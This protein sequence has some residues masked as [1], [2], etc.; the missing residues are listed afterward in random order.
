MRSYNSV[1][2]IPS[3]SWTVP[4]T[5]FSRDVC[6]LGCGGLSSFQYFHLVFPSDVLAVYAQIHSLKA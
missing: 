1:S 2:I 5:V 3:L 4:D 6:L